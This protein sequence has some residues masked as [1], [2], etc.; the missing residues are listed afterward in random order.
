MMT[1]VIRQFPI[2]YKI[3]NKNKLSRWQINI[4][5]TDEIYTIKTT[6]GEE[7]CKQQVQE[8]TIESKAKR[9]LIQQA[10]LEAASKWKEKTER[11]TY[12]EYIVE[13]EQIIRLHSSEYVNSLVINTFPSEEF[14]HEFGEFL[15]YF[16]LTCLFFSFASYIKQTRNK[17]FVPKFIRKKY[18]N[19]N[20]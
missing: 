12:K 13:E 15:I 18:V 5:K 7:G 8:R 11:D 9:S 6:F 16:G 14:R 20:M 2:L 17:R 4:E 19:V 10:N 3:N 1:E